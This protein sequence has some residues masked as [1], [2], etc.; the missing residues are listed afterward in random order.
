MSRLTTSSHPGGA[1]WNRQDHET[2]SACQARSPAIR[3]HT[4][5]AERPV[6]H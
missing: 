5:I 6:R 3:M 2:T 4:A 1:E